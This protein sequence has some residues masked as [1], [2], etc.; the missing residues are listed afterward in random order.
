M[1]SSER[2]GSWWG[3]VRESRRKREANRGNEE[4][5]EDGTDHMETMMEAKRRTSESQD[6]RQH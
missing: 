3:G 5:S 1:C 6:T 4:A 2:V